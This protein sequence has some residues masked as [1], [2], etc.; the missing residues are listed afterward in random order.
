MAQLPGQ[1]EVFAFEYF[2][3]YTLPMFR[4]CQPSVLWRYTIGFSAQTADAV[5]D[6]TIALGFHQQLL[7][8]AEDVENFGP[9]TIE[10]QNSSVLLYGRAVKSFRE[11]LK[12]SSLAEAPILALCCVLFIALECL[13]GSPM[14]LLLHLQY[15]VRFTTDAIRSCGA[16]MA[17]EI[18][19]IADLLQQF[20]INAW[21]YGTSHSSSGNH[22]LVLQDLDFEALSLPQSGQASLSSQVNG[23]TTETIYTVR[24]LMHPE[25]TQ[26]D[27]VAQFGRLYQHRSKSI[28][29][30]SLLAREQPSTANR[31]FLEAKMIMTDV[32]I[33]GLLTNRSDRMKEASMYQDVLDVLETSITEVNAVGSPLSRGLKPQALSLENGAIHVLDTIIQAVPGTPLESRALRLLQM[34]PIRE[35]LWNSQAPLRLRQARTSGN[36]M[37]R[38]AQRWTL[39]IEVEDKLASIND[40]VQI[41]AGMPERLAII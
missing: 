20:C 41:A 6:I 28:Y 25:A 5:R 36:A 3:L 8:S 35:G 24:R 16:G 17:G 4:T 12:D 2:N 40:C 13:R 23:L 14:D 10:P 11:M 26:N 27:R 39:A 21:L 18:A 34:C 37:T 38:T 9:S 30:R 31:G 29:L 33:T 22:A 7:E 32:S 15:A 1:L 19:A